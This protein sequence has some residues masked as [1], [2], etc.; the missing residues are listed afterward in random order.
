ML[1]VT[2]QTTTSPEKKGKHG[3]P[4]DC[5][6]LPPQRVFRTQCK[7]KEARQNPAISYV[8]KG[9]WGGQRN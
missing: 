9:I 7:E 1:D 4:S 3:K 5:L 2:Q 6:N 8:E